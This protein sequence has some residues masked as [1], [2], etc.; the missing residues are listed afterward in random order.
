MKKYIL[1]FFCLLCMLLL[2]SC[3]QFERINQE[4]IMSDDVEIKPINIIASATASPEP[5]LIVR[6]PSYSR[7]PIRIK[8]NSPDNVE[9]PG[10]YQL[11]DLPGVP[12]AVYAFTDSDNKVQYRVYADVDELEDGHIM[13]MLSGFFAAKLYLTEGNTFVIEIDK[14]TYP[15]I[16]SAEIPSSLTPCPA[17]TKANIGKAI[18]TRANE[19]KIYGSGYEKTGRVVESNPAPDSWDGLPVLD[20]STTEIYLPSQL[21]SAGSKYPYLYYYTDLYGDK[22]YR[23]YATSNGYDSGFYFSDEFGTIA[24]GSL[25]IDFETD[26]GGEYFKKRKIIPHPQDG[27]YRLPVI[28]TLSNGL[29]ISATVVYSKK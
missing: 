24:D 15:V 26:L 4:S 29:D 2:T 3:S 16:I 23:R 12:Y 14:E 27:L 21:K 8:L 5:Q 19:Q 7:S 25:K 18:K 17:P 9:V 20:E 6:K 22:A 13:N 11:L 10:F 1:L 28:I